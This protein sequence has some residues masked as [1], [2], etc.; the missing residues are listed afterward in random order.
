[1]YGHH[2]FFL[3]NRCHIQEIR[4]RGRSP[5]RPKDDIEKS[6]ATPTSYPTPRRVLARLSP[7]KPNRLANS[8][9]APGKKA[10]CKLDRLEWRSEE[11]APLRFPFLFRRPVTGLPYSIYPN[12]YALIRVRFIQ[13][14]TRQVASAQF[15]N[16]APA[17]Q[18]AGP[19]C[20]HALLERN[21]VPPSRAM[22]QQRRR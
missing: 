6:A 11:F 16:P 4:A 18:S 7:H 15:Q 21:P 19:E 17:P 5:I 13:A 22:A 10:K 3:R 1:M 12:R 2:V 8:G 20:R 9:N 14:A